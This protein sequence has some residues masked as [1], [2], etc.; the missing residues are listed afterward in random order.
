MVYVRNKMGESKENGNSN[1]QTW[2]SADEVLTRFD[3]NKDNALDLKEF[4]E[5]CLELFGTDEIKQHEDKIAGIF[6]VLDAD[7]DGLLKGREWQT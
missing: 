3:R 2:Q 5:L 7:S 4:L 6:C 1:E